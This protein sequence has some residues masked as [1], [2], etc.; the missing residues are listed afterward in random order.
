SKCK[1]GAPVSVVIVE[2]IKHAPT[3]VWGV[4][5]ALSVFGAL[6]M[7]DRVV[8]RTRVLVMPIALGAYSFW[9]AAQAFQM[10]WEVLVAWAVGMGVM[11]WAARW[12][13]WPRKV[14][15]LPDRNAFAV[16][17]SVAPLLAMLAVFAVRY[18]VA[19]NLILHPQW[20][21]QAGVAIL[22]ALVYGLLSGVFAMRARSIL[23][24]GL[25]AGRLL[26][27]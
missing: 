25:P 6:Q 19:V 13:P 9:G 8:S 20:R 14:E 23:A 26:P 15:F 17:G 5:L 18:V 1:R 3:Y 4:L 22:G 10:Q 2:V 21:S 11:L 12:M 16:A 27:A 7:R 24:H